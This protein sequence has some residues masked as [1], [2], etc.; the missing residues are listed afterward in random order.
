M[1]GTSTEQKIRTL[2][3]AERTDKTN[4]GVCRE[5]QISEQASPRA[6]REC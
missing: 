5:Q 4:L 1:K 2:R 6:K 3:E